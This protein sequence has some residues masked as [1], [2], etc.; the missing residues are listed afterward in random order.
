MDRETS[1]QLLEVLANFDEMEYRRLINGPVAR[2]GENEDICS[3]Y[4]R[5]ETDDLDEV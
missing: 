3:R 4:E 2:I 5:V 1:R